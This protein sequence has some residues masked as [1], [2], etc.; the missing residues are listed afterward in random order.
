M[1]K[2]LASLTIA[3]A[4]SV[5]A[6]PLSQAASIKIAE[7]ILVPDKI[8]SDAYVIAGNG[9]IDA[10]VTADLYVAGGTLIINGDVGQDL[11]VAGGKVTVI[12]DVAGDIR[13][14]GGEVSVY[15]KVGEDLLAVGGEVDVGKNALINGDLMITAGVLRL[16]GAVKGSLKGATDLTIFN[17]NVGKNVELSTDKIDMAPTAKI[18]GNLDY[19]SKLA[20]KIPNGV[21]AGTVK[22][23]KIEHQGN[24][25]KKLFSFA[26]SLIFLLLIVLLAPKTLVTVADEMKNSVLKSFGIGLATIVGTVAAM[27]FLL[28]SIVGIPLAIVCLAA[29]L[30]ICLFS[31][32]YAAA[33]LAKYFFDY[34]NY[35]KAKL[36]GVISLAML[37]YYLI[38]LIP[39]L[40]WA[41][42]MVFFLTGV[43]G[44]MM[45]KI[46]FMK[47]LRSKKLL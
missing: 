28:M 26:S 9:S 45:M 36:F 18:L 17:G 42:N 21:V 46:S 34:K 39:Y 41:I 15:G 30:I 2:I 44:I 3:L 8:M 31:K 1:K 14:F 22:F 40:G 35:S 24:W 13:L 25:F 33:W 5:F 19:S 37:A 29:L 16:N 11:V 47:M 32:V 6:V 4:I 7:N 38:G 43:G 27:M 20:A 23:T 10:D 12:G